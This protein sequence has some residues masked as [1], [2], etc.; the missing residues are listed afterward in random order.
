ME[1]VS[2][3]TQTSEDTTRIEHVFNLFLWDRLVEEIR[4]ELGQMKN[5][6]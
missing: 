4:L 1:L 5:K 3:L 6:N 2:L